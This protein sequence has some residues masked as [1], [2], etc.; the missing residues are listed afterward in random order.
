MLPDAAPQPDLSLRSAIDIDLS[1]G[2]TTSDLHVNLS[3]R[4][5]VKD[6]INPSL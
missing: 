1:V 2:S 5:R 3:E 6:E 4:M